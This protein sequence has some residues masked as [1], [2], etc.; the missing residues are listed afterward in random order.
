VSERLLERRFPALPAELKA[1]RHAVQVTL[2]NCG[3]SEANTRDVVM[4]LDE[5]CQNVIRHAY[6]AER[7]GDIELAIDQQGDQLIFWLTDWA[8]AIDPAR[9]RP[10]DLDDVRP[11]G[12]GT[13]LIREVMDAADF[14]TAPPGCGNLLKM[15][16]RIA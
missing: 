15:V 7:R 13:H 12:L 10:R 11:G 6:G 16:K 1:T 9:V 3:M 8:P 2:A 4:A 14:V 5:A